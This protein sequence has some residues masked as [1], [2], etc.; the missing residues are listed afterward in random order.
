MHQDKKNVRARIHTFFLQVSFYER[1]LQR[2]DAQRRLL[3]A[4][5]PSTSTCTDNISTSRKFLK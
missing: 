5:Q 4:L 3:G 1:R 2:C